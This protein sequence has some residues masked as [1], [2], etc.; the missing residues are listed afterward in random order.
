MLSV[1]FWITA[2]RYRVIVCVVVPVASVYCSGKHHC[3][4]TGR[5]P[6]R[7]KHNRTD[8]Q[9]KNPVW[10]TSPT[11]EKHLSPVHRLQEGLRQ[12]M[13]R[14]TMGDHD[15]VQHQREAHWNHTKSLRKRN[16]CCIGP[17]NY[18]RMVSHISWSSS[19]VPALPNPLQ[20]ISRGYHDTCS[21]ELQRHHQHRGS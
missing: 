9:P 18:G 15:K 7:K 5:F 13:A 16:E 10:K 11:S 8:I 20:H 2:C 14:S 1:E 17:G 19:G 3:R 12:S 4:R 21:R 6:S